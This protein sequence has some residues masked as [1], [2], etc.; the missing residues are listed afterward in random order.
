MHRA[1]RIRCPADVLVFVYHYKLREP[2]GDISPDPIN[3]IIK[4]FA[5]CPIQRTAFVIFINDSSQHNII[6]LVIKKIMS[7]FKPI[8][9]FHFWDWLISQPYSDQTFIRLYL[10]KI[11][12]Y[13]VKVYPEL[14]RTAINDHRAELLHFINTQET[15]ERIL[16]AYIKSKIV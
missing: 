16:T 2:V 1:V 10:L 5:N 6:F 9:S 13:Y 15:S 4:T 8:N 14:V 7:I 12:K 11:I 3:I